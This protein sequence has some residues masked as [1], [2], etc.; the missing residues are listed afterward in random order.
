MFVSEG[1]SCK[2]TAVALHPRQV[3]VEKISVYRQQTSP[4]PRVYFFLCAHILRILEYT[5]W[6]QR[7][8]ALE[9]SAPL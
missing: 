3:L 1:R 4:T 5:A 6:W 9:I 2:S 7:K 8:E